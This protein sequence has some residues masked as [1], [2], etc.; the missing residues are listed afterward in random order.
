M[1]IAA[2]PAHP[3][4][5]GRPTSMP[6]PALL[7]KIGMDSLVS[8]ATVVGLGIRLLTAVPAPLVR[9][10][11]EWFVLGA[12]LDQ[13]GTE[14]AVSHALRDKSGTK[15]TLCASARVVSNGTVTP[16]LLLALQEW[17]TLTDSA[18]AP[19]VPTSA[20][21][22]ASGSQLV[23]QVKLGMGL[24][25]LKF[26]A[27][28]ELHG[29]EP[30]AL[31]PLLRIVQPAPST[32]EPD[33]WPTLPTALK[34]LRGTDPLAKAQEAAPTGPL[35]T[36]EL[37]P[38]FLSCALSVWCGRIPSA[39]QQEQAVP[40]VPISAEAVVFLSNPAITVEFGILP[41]PSVFALRDPSG[42]ATSASSVPTDSPIKSTLGASAHKVLSSAMDHALPFRSISV[43]QSPTHCGMASPASAIQATPSSVYSVSARGLQSVLPSVI[44][45]LASPT[46]LGSTAFANATKA[47]QISTEDVLF[48]HP[49]QLLTPLA[50]LPLTLIISKRD[51][52]LVQAV[53]WVVQAATSAPVVS[54][55]SIWT[56][57]LHCAWRYAVM[58]EDL[59]CSVTMEITLTGTVAAVTVRSK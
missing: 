7:H 57:F 36:E 4:K 56:S 24:D 16:V 22:V 54:L 49:I 13:T 33:V 41:F 28:Q 11:M 6:A 40:M 8:R 37:A 10:G 39:C 42:M 15:L 26:S 35:A 45:A 17:S 31:P 2:C 48:L 21:E 19:Q 25:A 43:L 38:Q 59:P 34:E 51:A 55:A 29:T 5:S 52:F 58:P 44:D 30:F 1:V 23:L 46:Q 27:L 9:I 50:M 20:T 14:S 3:D 47:S 53:A 32:M 12:I 18:P